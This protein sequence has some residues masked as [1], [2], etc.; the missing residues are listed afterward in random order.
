MTDHILKEHI[1]EALEW[2]PGIDASDMS[3][4]VDRGVV[5]LTGDVATAAEHALA[6]QVVGGVFGVAALINELV[7][8]PAGCFSCRQAGSAE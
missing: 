6:A 8:G 7:V 5:T 3:I 2:E 1:L 4:H